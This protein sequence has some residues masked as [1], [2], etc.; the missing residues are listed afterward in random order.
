MKKIFSIFLLLLVSCAN[1]QGKGLRKNFVVPNIQTVGTE[2]YL[3][4]NSDYIF[5][6]ESLHTFELKIPESSLKKIDSD[7]TKEEY[8]EGILIFRGDTLSPVGIR[9]K[10]S[11]GAFVGCTSG[12]D[13]S[14]PSGKKICTK[15]SMKVKINWKGRKDKFYDLTK[16]QFHS[17][18]IDPTQMHE[19]LGYWFFRS[20]GVVAPRSVHAKLIINN[21]YSGLYALT[22]QIDDN[23][24]RY[25]FDEPNGN[26]YKE[27]W[28]ID[29]KG[30]PQNEKN[31]YGGLKTNEDN[32]PDLKLIKKF[33]ELIAESDLSQSLQIVSEYMNIDKIISYAVVDRAIRNDD[34]VFHWYEFGQGASSHNYY[35]Y[36]ESIKQKI[37]LIPWDLDNSFENISLENP[38]TFIPDDW[39]ET[40]NDCIPFPYGDWGFWQRSASCDKIIRA[41][42]S[43]K[44]EYKKF[45]SKLNDLYVDQAPIL[46][47]KWSLQIKDATIQASKTHKDALPIKK[48]ERHL[49][50]LKAQIYLMK[51]R[52]SK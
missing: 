32:N 27:V 34:G 26:L 38:V 40:S 44:D 29:H 13:W 15:L 18:N 30:N 14:N 16:L 36:E 8:V 4:G 25:N 12:K 17:Q 45:Q 52:L 41:W 7:P 28:P 48:W 20:M 5:D 6:Q 47:D 49:E 42:S 2:N 24:V 11:V 51:M 43:Y 21:K 35:W 33:G 3:N 23:F 9:Y 1:H 31:L 39:G 22:E 19:R 10:G 46:I 37:H 50:L